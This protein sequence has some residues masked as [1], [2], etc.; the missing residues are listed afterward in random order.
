MKKIMILIAWFF[1][2][3]SSCSNNHPI[4]N[5]KDYNRFMRAGVLK[6]QVG[7]I[8]G[9]ISFW[10]QRLQQ[11]TGSFICM[12]EIAGYLLRLFKATGN[13][14]SLR[15]GDSL[16]KISSAK[17]N[18]T[19]PELLYS[20][21]Q[22][23][24]TQHQFIQSASYISSAEKAK[25]DLYTIRLLQFDTYMELGKFAEADKS[26]ESLKDKESFEYI[27]RKAKWEDHNG[28]LSGAIALLEKAYEKVKDKNKSLN[29]WVLSNLADMYGH[30]GRIDEAYNA[31][32][33]V[34]EKDSTN[35]YCLKGIAWITYAHDNNTR[36]AKRILQYILTQTEMPDLKL[37]LAEIAETEGNMKEKQRLIN[38]FVATVTKPGYGDMY[39]K[40]LVKIYTEDT[41]KYQKALAIAEKELSNRFTPET[42]DWMAW[43]QYKTGNIKKAYETTRGFVVKRTFEPDAILHTAFIYAANGKKKEA[44]AMLN[45]CLESSFELGPVS[46]KEIKEK[47]ASL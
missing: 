29:G 36:E 23:C 24:V 33:S 3:L 46:V 6:E 26:L 9:E 12:S 42:N 32:L 35:L 31:Y 10:Q 39:N 28:N 22:T 8:N 34:L 18:H 16:L 15:T 45:E 4:A 20:L 1:I 38:E 19:N 41:R 25:G 47:L 30:A 11:D 40:Y 27:I 14:A 43:V 5:A 17:L 13:I 44:R 21:S 2:M 7:K 37:M